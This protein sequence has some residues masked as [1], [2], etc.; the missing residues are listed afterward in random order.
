M[1]RLVV[2]VLIAATGA[3]RTTEDPFPNPIPTTDGASQVGYVEFAVFPGRNGAPPRLRTLLTEPG[4]RYI[5]FLI[6]GLIGLNL[7]G[8]GMWGIGFTVVEAR[9]R[10]LLK[11]LAASPMARG[12]PPSR[13][14]SSATSRTTSGVASGSSAAV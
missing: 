5:D 12:R 14:A 9:S 7:M 3:C 4:S 13:R 11:R 2:A 8:S 6:P 10:K 1:R